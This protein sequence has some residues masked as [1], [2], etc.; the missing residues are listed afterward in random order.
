[1]AK[2][3]KRKPHTKPQGVWNEFTAD[4][5]TGISCGAAVGAAGGWYIY[6]TQKSIQDNL[7]GLLQAGLGIG[8]MMLSKHHY[9]KVWA[10]AWWHQQPSLR[11]KVLVCYPVSLIYPAAEI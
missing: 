3:A 6:T 8:L 10:W 5:L 1:M 2:K 11:V 9:S 7:M 4:R